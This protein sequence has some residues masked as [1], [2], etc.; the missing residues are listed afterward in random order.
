MSSLV[1]SNP[2]TQDN[3]SV[4]PSALPT[5]PHG[6]WQ[7]EAFFWNT[8]ISLNFHL[9]SCFLNFTKWQNFDSGLNLD[10]PK[11]NLTLLLV[12][13]KENFMLPLV[14][15]N[16]VTQD[17]NTVVP[18]T[19]PTWPHGKDVFIRNQT[20]AILKFSALTTRPFLECIRLYI[21]VLSQN[22]NQP[23]PALCDW[24]V[25]WENS[26]KIA[27]QHGKRSAWHLEIFYSQLLS[28]ELINILVT[29]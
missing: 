16:L 10:T 5:W 6:F 14:G 2:G 26:C 23:Q 21:M 20:W 28:N 11:T 8:C 13:T 1:E 22:K 7:S 25:M 17:N 12:F 29:V 9:L 3:N 27:R 15:S 18:S 4:V 24:Y 19:L